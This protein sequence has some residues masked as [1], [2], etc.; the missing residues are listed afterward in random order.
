MKNIGTAGNLAVRMLDQSTPILVAVAVG[1]PLPFRVD[2]VLATGTTAT[3][4]VGLV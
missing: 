4:I 3:N 2:K 1:V